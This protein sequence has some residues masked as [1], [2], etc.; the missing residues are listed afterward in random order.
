M[1]NPLVE[2]A[3][4]KIHMIEE[5]VETEEVFLVKVNTFIK[6]GSLAFNVARD[7]KVR[8]LVKM[9]HTGAK[10]RGLFQPPTYNW[11]RSNR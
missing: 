2:H 7:E 10:R 11:Y 9:A 6:L 3:V 5:S 4:S 8:E 1:S